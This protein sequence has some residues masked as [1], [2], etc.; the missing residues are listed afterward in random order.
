MGIFQRLSMRSNFVRGRE[1]YT[2]A[3]SHFGQGAPSSEILGPTFGS[4]GLAKCD[5]SMGTTSDDSVASKSS[6]SSM[7]SGSCLT[8]GSIGG[9]GFAFGTGFGDGVGLGFDTA[10]ASRN[11]AAIGGGS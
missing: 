10:G 8:W 6:S 7:G 11:G 1:T 9:A 5:A 2:G 3:P 4:S